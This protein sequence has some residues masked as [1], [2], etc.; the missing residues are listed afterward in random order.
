MSGGGRERGCGG[1][2]KGGRFEWAGVA[3]AC[4]GPCLTT[5]HRL[6]GPIP[7]ADPFMSE[8]GMAPSWHRTTGRACPPGTAK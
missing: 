8:R 7:S 5:E 2:Q 3:G 6:L 4:L 1:E